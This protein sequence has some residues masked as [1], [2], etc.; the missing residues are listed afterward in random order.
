MKKPKK[1]TKLKKKFMLIVMMIIMEND[2]D[3][4]DDVFASLIV[5]MMI[6]I[7]PQ[8]WMA[9][10]NQLELNEKNCIWIMM[11]FFFRFFVRKKKNLIFHLPKRKPSLDHCTGP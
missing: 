9:Y 2:D 11:K 1:N 4:D 6:I 5:I 8:W 10:P 3:D 7:K